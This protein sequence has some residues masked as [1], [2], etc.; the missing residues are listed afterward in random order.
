MT[1]IQPAPPTP[2]TPQSMTPTASSAYDKITKVE[3]VGKGTYGIV[4]AALPDKYIHKE[5]SKI[6]VKRNLVDRATDFTGSLREVDILDRL[7]DHPF[8]VQMLAIVFGDPFAS[9]GGKM[10]PVRQREYKDDKIHFIFEHAAYDL[11][12][13]IYDM[14]AP[15]AHIKW[16]VVQIMLGVEFLHAKKLIHRDLKPPNVLVFPQDDGGVLFKICDFGL[17]KPYTRQG[18]QSPRT[19]T[20]W[21][22]APEISLDWS[23]YSGK[24]DLWSVGCILFEMISRRPLLHNVSEKDNSMIN[25]LLGTMP[26]PVSSACLKKMFKTRRVN[27]TAVS[28]PYRRKSWAEQTGHNAETIASFNSVEAGP[29]TFEQYMDLMSHLLIIDPD[30]RWD[31]IQALN[32]AFFAGYKDFIASVRT[33]FP[34]VP[35]VAI[36]NTILDCIERKWAMQ[37]AFGCFNDRYSH[38]WYRHRVL[39]QAI[40]LFDRYLSWA[41]KNK[42]LRGFETVDFG[43]LHTQSESVLRFYVCVYVAIKYFITLAAPIPFRQL[44]EPRHRDH[45]SLVIAEQFEITLIVDVLDFDIYRDTLYEV[46][47]AFEDKLDDFDVRELLIVF[48]SAQEETK[49]LTGVTPTILYE[50]YKAA[51]KPVPVLPMLTPVKT[52]SANTSTAPSTIVAVKTPSVNTVV[53]KKP[54]EAVKTG[55]VP[56]RP[57]ATTVPSTTIVPSTTVAVMKK[58]PAALKPVEQLKPVTAT[59]PLKPVEQLKPITKPVEALKLITKAAP[60][61]PVEQLKP[62]EVIPATTKPTIPPKPVKFKPVVTTRS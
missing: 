21:Y 41:W 50:K 17:A 62:L 32:H 27:L 31:A 20:P 24:A 25:A 23:D 14:D 45:A 2:P 8:M 56:L 57:L 40:D 1:V 36:P 13:F 10:S 59:V 51:R 47:D 15:L 55:L 52:P 33:A 34:P 22:R 42:P 48:G 54:L 19:V 18:V 39:F 16:A 49:E 43:R 30:E 44:V 53:I 4:Y 6:A 58:K 46:A 11:H 38:A 37:V 60:L 26:Q 12:H 28:N 61:K 3:R 7:R 29:G 5:K 9:S 35:R